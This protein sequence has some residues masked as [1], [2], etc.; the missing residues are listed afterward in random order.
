MPYTVAVSFDKFREAIELPGDHRET[1]TARKDSIIS[2]LKNDFEILDAFATG[3]LPRFTA[4]RGHADLDVMVAL[5]YGK[6]INN[7]K[8]SEVLQAVRN[9][10]GG[11]RTNV[12]NNGQAV[13]LHYKTW[14]DVNIVPVSRSVDNAGLVAHYN[15]P[16]L[17]TETW[18]ESRP[19]DHSEVM[20]KK[21][22]SCGVAFKRIIKMI[23]W[24]NHQ[25]S[26][27]LRSF[28]IEVIAINVF[29]SKL[30]DYPWDVFQ[31]FDKACELAASS[32]WYDGSLADKY[33]DWST[34]QEVVKRLTSA[35]D[36]A[37]EAWY[38]TYDN[39]DDDEKAIGIWRQ[40]F[41][42]EFPAFGS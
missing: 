7:K 4:V 14:P 25:H 31:Y 32:L 11:Y 23:K 8:P 38:L 9:A 34:R 35:R 22:D 16:D 33:L 42:D 39:N 41:G 15:V 3:S 37:R 26:S 17:N 1:A 40:I 30:D 13:T 18:I 12:R 10:L 36:K 27:L 21:N 29:S 5:H 6:H 19:K 20:T 28:H 2:L 24:W